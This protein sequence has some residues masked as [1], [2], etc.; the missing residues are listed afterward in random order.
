M[1][2]SEKKTAAQ[3]ALFDQIHATLTDGQLLKYS[4]PARAQTLVDL[5]LAYRYAAGGP[6]PG[7]GTVAKG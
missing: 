4:A 3:D 5:A 1:Y 6:Q 7:G 2:E